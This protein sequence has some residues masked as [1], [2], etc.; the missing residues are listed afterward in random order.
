MRVSDLQCSPRLLDALAHK[1]HQHLGMDFSG[2]RRSDLLRRLLRLAREQ[3]LPDTEHWLEALAFA[4]W[5]ASQ[6]Q[7]LVP[8][9]SVGETYFRRDSEAFGWLARNH[10]KPLLARRRREGQRY[11]RLW[12]AACC[13]G[14]E[15]YG[16]L[17]LI[18][19]LLGTERRSWDVE[20]LATDINEDFLTHAR[21]GVYGRNAFRGNDDAFRR[22]YFQAEGSRWRV[23][24]DWLDRIRFVRFNLTDG[25]QPSPMPSADLILCR[26]VLMYFSP[27]RA[28]AALHRLLASLE[29][30]GV[31]LL[32]SV[33]AGIATQAGLKGCMAA[34]NYALTLPGSI[35][36]KELCVPRPVASPA[37]LLWPGGDYAAAAP[38][39]PAALSRTAPRRVT[40][41]ENEPRVIET[42]P[43]VFLAQAQ[44]ALAQGKSE[45]ARESLHAYLGCPGLSPGQ[46]HETCLLLARSWAD[47]LRIE[48]ARCYLERAL[49]LDAASTSAYWLSALLEQQAGNTR[50]ALSALQK[51]LYL[52][53]DF[54]L[55]YFLQARLLR[56]DDQAQASS[57]SLQVCR[58]LLSE[59]AEDAPVPRADG[60]SCAQ[61][62]RLC[63]QIVTRDQPWP[64]R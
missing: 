26:N 3:R 36:A 23:R 59:Q 45:V 63:D 49:A 22:R 58:Q 46:Q 39:E 37:Q 2:E 56:S 60:M 14:E 6:I 12:S 51:A 31:L 27:A 20:L 53:P 9:F 34:S 32:S 17:F 54:I 28:S 43:A 10:L 11:L 47:E 25:R 38:A 33:E 24:S 5:N 64:N 4:D 29:P 50:G 15:A 52:E 41:P 44:Q 42:D 30:N 7:A 61:L 48:P 13:T 8:A 21:R 57:K 19:E 62:L 40:T 35:G 16:L 18:D 55:G 1:V